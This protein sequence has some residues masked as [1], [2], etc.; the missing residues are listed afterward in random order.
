MGRR[1]GLFRK[2]TITRKRKVKKLEMDRLSEGYKRAIDNVW[3]PIKRIF[4]SKSEFLGPP[5]K[6]TSYSGHHV[7]AMTGKSCANKKVPFSQI[8]INILANFGCF[9][10]EKKTIFLPKNAFQLNVKTAVSL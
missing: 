6:I 10:G 1:L 9:F 8:N 5:K 2:T 3:G 4:G 7:L